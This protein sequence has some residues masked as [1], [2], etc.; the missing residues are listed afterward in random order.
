MDTLPSNRY[1]V[2]SFFGAI[3]VTLSRAMPLNRSLGEYIVL[4]ILLGR[5][6]SRLFYYLKSRPQGYD[7]R[8]STSIGLLVCQAEISSLQDYNLSQ[9]IVGFSLCGN[10]QQ[11]KK[12]I[13]GRISNLPALA[14]VS[15][16]N[17][18]GQDWVA[19]NCAEPETFA[20][21]PSVQ[22]TLRDLVTD[23]NGMS[24]GESETVGIMSMSLTLKLVENESRPIKGKPFCVLCK[25][26]AQSM[27]SSLSSQILD[28]CPV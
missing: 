20:H 8:F 14:T 1:T 7:T 2:R 12:F 13:R 4:V 23:F 9:A 11:K 28:I 5:L 10:T 25:R 18:P 24:G 27:S 6:L 21:L 17:R 26:L 22:Q 16:S 15:T 3:H 19:G